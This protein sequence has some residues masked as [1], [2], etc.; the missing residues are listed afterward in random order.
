MP[1]IA[2]YYSD[3]PIMDNALLPHVGRFYS[4]NVTTASLDHAMWFHTPF[5]LSEW[6]L[7]A[8]DGPVAAG[9]R[10]L[11]RGLLFARDGRLVC[12][13]AQEVLMRQRR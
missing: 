9:A 1:A 10:G 7:F 4:A 5:D 8:Q 11:T 3:D 12:S 6:H 2:A 13:V